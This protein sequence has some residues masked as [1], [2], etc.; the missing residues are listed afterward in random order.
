MGQILLAMRLAHTRGIVHRNLKPQNVLLTPDGN[1]KVTDF[2]IAVAFCR[3][4]FDSD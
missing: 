4:K 1:A 3:D 2:D